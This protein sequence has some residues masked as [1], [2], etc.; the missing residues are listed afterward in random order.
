VIAFNNEFIKTRTLGLNQSIH[1][2]LKQ[3]K[4]EGLI[5]KIAALSTYQT[6]RKIREDAESPY[7]N[8]FY[9]EYPDSSILNLSTTWRNIL[10]WNRTSTAY[11]IQ[12]GHVRQQNQVLQ[13]SGFERRELSDL[14]FRCRISLLK[15]MDL[16]L[17]AREGMRDN[18]S[19]IL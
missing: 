10:Y 17:N 19:P 3:L 1:L 7:W 15:K 12:V 14:T 4:K 18:E 9:N 2:D 5:S 11:D 16:V 13:T 6:N 8:P